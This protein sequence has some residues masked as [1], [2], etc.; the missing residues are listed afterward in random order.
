MSGVFSNIFR[1][2]KVLGGTI[3]GV[4]ISDSTIQAATTSASGAVELSTDAET[5]TGTAT[6]KVTTP[7][8]IT[9]RIP[10]SI[11]DTTLSGTPKILTHIDTDGTPYYFKAYPTKA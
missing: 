2:I 7:A 1:R 9:A 10:N 11:A 4:T 8:N 6:D 5:I 3:S